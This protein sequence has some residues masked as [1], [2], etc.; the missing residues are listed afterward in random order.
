[1]PYLISWTSSLQWFVRSRTGTDWTIL[2]SVL[3]HCLWKLHSD[4]FWGWQSR[5][6]GRCR[7][8]I[9]RKNEISCT[10]WE[11][12]KERWRMFLKLLAEKSLLKRKVLK[13]ISKLLKQLPNLRKDIEDFLCENR[14]KADVREELALLHFLWSIKSNILDTK[15]R[16]CL[17]PVGPFRIG[18][19]T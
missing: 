13:R 11:E 17:W 1:M 3:D 4:R 16:W 15:R 14:I 5:G 8:K 2:P 7:W 18:R 9:D 6:L 19:I 10:E 12:N